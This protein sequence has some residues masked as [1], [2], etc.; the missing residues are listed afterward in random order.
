MKPESGS[1]VKLTFHF[2][3]SAHRIQKMLDYGQTQ[4]GTGHG[5]GAGLV[6]PVK[7]VKDAGQIFGWDTD[8]GILD[9]ELDTIF[10]FPCTHPYG[11]VLGSILD[12]VVDQIY[13]DLF[14]PVRIRQDP[15]RV[16]R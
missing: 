14:Q 7:T 5:T 6:D 9:P 2:D 13:P 15:H 16:F 11:A 3:R 12:G 4:T 10:R 8:A 1:P